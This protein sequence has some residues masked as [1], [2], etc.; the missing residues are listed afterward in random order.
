VGPNIVINVA[1]KPYTAWRN[2]KFTLQERS[3]PA[4]SGDL[5]T[6]VADGVTNLMK[7]ALHLNPHANGLSGLPIVGMAL[8]AGT[9]KYLTLTYTEV[10]SATDVSYTAQVSGD[11]ATWNSGG[12]Y[13]ALV[14]STANPDGVTHAVTVRDLVPVSSDNARFMR[15][16]VARN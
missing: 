9:D 5:A 1:A 15:L 2:Q 3:D 16:T 7:Y 4:I 13:T 10:D 6:P 14:S 11:L 12:D 8:G